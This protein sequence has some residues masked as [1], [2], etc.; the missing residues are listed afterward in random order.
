MLPIADGSDM[1][2]SLRNPG[3]YNNVVG[4]RPSPGLVP[5]WPSSL[6]WVQ[7]S[8]KGPLART[9][10]DIALMLTAIAGAD[11]RAPLSLDVDP[12]SFARP[13]ERDFRGVR[14][15]WCP[16]LGGLPL[17]PRV[18]TALEGRR[19]V[20][21]ELGCAVEE[22]A[23]DLGAAEGVFQTLRAF[24]LATGHEE[25]FEADKPHLKPEAVWNIEK[26]MGL[27]G[28]EVGRALV[29]L[30]EV[31]ETMRTFMESYEYVLCAVNQVP[32]FDI[33]TRYP[34]AALVGVPMPGPGHEQA[35]RSGQVGHR[36]S[37][38][39][40]PALARSGLLPGTEA[41]S[42]ASGRAG[43][44]NGSRLTYDVLSGTRRGGAGRSGRVAPARRR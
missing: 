29:K 34:E 27:S 6:P 38:R 44:G 40:S 23:P 43:C 17:D 3:N 10:A 30:A 13:L 24:L 1:G 14:V 5:T 8:V 4:F 9:V 42:E 41:M 15:A 32:P 33:E 22:A 26:G 39:G 20:F 31:A 7:L 37:W 28:L 18:R 12:A 11:P 16:D 21:E 35:V 2:G 36:E 25:S 19:S